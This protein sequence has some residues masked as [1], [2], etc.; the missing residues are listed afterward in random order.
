FAQRGSTAASARAISSARWGR[1]SRAA[2]LPSRRK[3]SVGQSL[4]PNER[5]RR[6]PLASA[7]LIWRTSECAASASAISGCARR[8]QPHQGLPNSST[9]GPASASTSLRLGSTC[10]YSAAT[11]INPESGKK[12]TALLTRRDGEPRTERDEERAGE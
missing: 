3:T 9:V 1:T 12:R 5:P 10:E 6:R 8:H 4:T 7:T 11:V 2:S